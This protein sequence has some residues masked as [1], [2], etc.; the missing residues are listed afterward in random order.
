[1]PGWNLTCRHPA[2]GKQARLLGDTHRP[3]H[4]PLQP[5]RLERQQPARGRGGPAEALCPSGSWP[6][7]AAAPAGPGLAAGGRSDRRGGGAAAGLG[8]GR[9]A[10]GS[11]AAARGEGLGGAD[12]K[13]GA[14]AGRPAA[15]RPLPL[16][17][18]PCSLS[19]LHGA[20]LSKALPQGKAGWP[21]GCCSGAEPAAS[22]AGKGGGGTPQPGSQERAE[23]VVPL[24]T[25][26]SVGL[27]IL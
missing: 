27:M 13:A 25:R 10:S 4:G 9:R 17:P 2:L 8:E 14:G 7:L 6:G 1:M 3:L 22:L 15:P 21:P 19:R 20:H 23:L 18:A 24:Y 11:E 12:G 26:L 5:R 16:A